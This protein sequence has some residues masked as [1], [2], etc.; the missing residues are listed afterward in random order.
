MGPLSLPATDFDGKEYDMTNE[1]QCPNTNFAQGLLSMLG[2]NGGRVINMCVQEPLLRPAIGGES[3]PQLTYS[4][5]V[6]AISK[7]ALEP[8]T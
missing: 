8:R 3:L 1:H 6:Y 7:V 2:R 4:R 5:T